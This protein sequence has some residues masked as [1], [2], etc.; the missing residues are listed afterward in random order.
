MLAI[1]PIHVYRRTVERAVEAL[2]N[3]R[4]LARYLNVPPDKVQLWRNGLEIPPL[5]LFLSCV[6]LILERGG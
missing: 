2:G 3:E 6:D 1:A 4:K 5:A